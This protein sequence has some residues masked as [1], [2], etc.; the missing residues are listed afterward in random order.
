MDD[1]GI[2]MYFEDVLDFIIC[3]AVAVADE[4]VQ[5]DFFKT[6]L[7]EVDTTKLWEISLDVA[8]CC[9]PGRVDIGWMA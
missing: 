8:C 2:Y 4:G 1:F 9:A 6:I 7:L 5:E 3:D